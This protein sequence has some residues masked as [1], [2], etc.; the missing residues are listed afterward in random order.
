MG[1]VATGRA[2]GVKSSQMFS[3]RVVSDFIPD[4]SRPRITTTVTSDWAP[5]ATGGHATWM[6][7]RGGKQWRRK[8]ERNEERK[9]AKNIKLKVATLN[10]GTMTGKEREVAELMKQRGVDTLCV[11][12]TRWKGEK[13]KC[14]GRGYKMWY[15]ESGNKNNGVGIIVK[16][17]HVDRVVDM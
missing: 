5:R 12:E 2:S 7:R 4:R 8:K 3:M 1:R 15:C 9:K 10:V 6:Q 14:I 11:Q 17:K 16:K 13:A